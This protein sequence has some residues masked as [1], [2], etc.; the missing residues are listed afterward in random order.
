MRFLIIFNLLFALLE[1]LHVGNAGPINDFLEGSVKRLLFIQV[2]R[3]HRRMVRL[4]G[5]SLKLRVKKL[6]SLQV[7]HIYSGRVRQELDVWAHLR[8]P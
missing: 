4:S 6:D 2:L 5:W 8:T 3:F 1:N 7:G